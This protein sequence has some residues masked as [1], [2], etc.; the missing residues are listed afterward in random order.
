LPFCIDGREVRNRSLRREGFRKLESLL[1]T[2]Y[3]PSWAES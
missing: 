2:R 3:K 1:T